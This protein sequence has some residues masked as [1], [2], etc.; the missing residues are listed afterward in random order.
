L[1]SEKRPKCPHFVLRCPP[2]PYMIVYNSERIKKIHAQKPCGIILQGFFFARK[3]ARLMPRKPKRPCRFPGCPN[4]TDGVT[5]RSTPRSWNSTTRSSSAATLPARGTA[6][7]GN[8]S[9]T[10]RPQASALRAVPEG[11]TLR[12]GRGSPPHHSSLRGRNNDDESNLMSL[13]RSCHEKIHRRPRRPLMI[14]AVFSFAQ[15][16]F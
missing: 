4:L 8:E 2:V 10:V 1:R 16:I 6:G 13:C 11:R 9:V 15:E 5:A 14:F 3:E 7:L 12:C